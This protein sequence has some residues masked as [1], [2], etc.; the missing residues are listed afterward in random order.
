MR[1]SNTTLRN[2]VMRNL[3]LSLRELERSQRQ[4]ASGRA[5]SQPSDSPVGIAQLLGVNSVLAESEQFQA[6]V[7]DGLAWL[8]MTDTTLGTVGD[9]FHRARELALAGANDTMP[10]QAKRYNAREVDQLLRHVIALA[11]SSLDGTR[12]LFGGTHHGDVPFT[13]TEGADGLIAAVTPATPTA[14]QGVVNYEVIRNVDMPVNTEGHA[15]FVAGGLFDALLAARDGLLGTGDLQLALGQLATAFT[16][17]LD[18]RAVAGARHNRLAMTEERYEAQ[19]VILSELR[20]QIGDVDMAEAV[21]EF[22]TR[23]HVYQAALA[24]SA[25]VLQPTLLDYLR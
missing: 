21:M 2:N 10:D 16:R 25:R 22:R 9:A 12:Y 15:L 19:R 4:M 8:S 7:R 18:A 3:Q 1:I 24:A 5:I 20:S 17:L 13:I 23:E 6:N 11:N 14:G